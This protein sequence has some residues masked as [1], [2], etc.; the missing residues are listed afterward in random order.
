LTP[1]ELTNAVKTLQNKLNELESARKGP[2]PF[3]QINI[4]VESIEKKLEK[5]NDTIDLLKKEVTKLGQKYIML[6]ARASR[7]GK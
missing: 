1:L 6:N 5:Q 3:E 2:F 7:N 4:L